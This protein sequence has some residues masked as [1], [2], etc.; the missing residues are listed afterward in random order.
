VLVGLVALA[1]LAVRARGSA[2]PSPTD[3]RLWGWY[4]HFVGV[5]WAALYVTVYLV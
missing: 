5:V 3:V 1:S 2:A 4:W